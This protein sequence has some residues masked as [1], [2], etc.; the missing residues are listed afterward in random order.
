M[1]QSIS[2]LSSRLSH[3]SGDVPPPLVGASATLVDPSSSTSSLT[4]SSAKLYVFGGR[5]VSNRRMV[6]DLYELD[7]ETLQWKKLGQGP[8]SSDTNLK[9]LALA[10]PSASSTSSSSLSSAK[11]P[12]P[13]Y[14]HSADLWEGRIVIFG[15]MGYAPSSAASH[16]RDGKTEELC[17]LD[18]IIAYD[19][20][21]GTWDYDFAP[22]QGVADEALQ[23]P[24]IVA[25]KPAPRYAHLSSISGDSLIIIGGQNMTNQYVEHINVFSLSRRRW[26]ASQR[27]QRQC[28]SY[29]SLAVGSRYI[30]T[31]GERAKCYPRGRDPLNGAHDGA[32]ERGNSFGP[33][34]SS[35]LQRDRATSVS[36]QRSVNS[37]RSHLS[38]SQSAQGDL[39]NNSSALRDTGA[40]EVSGTSWGPNP[41]LAPVQVEQNPLPTS[42][43]P[44]NSGAAPVYIY[45]NYNFTDVR[46]ELELIRVK[47]SVCEAP[48]DSSAP[49]TRARATSFGSQDSETDVALPL[50]PSESHRSSLSG[51]YVSVED[52]SS[53]MGGAALPPGLRFPTG[54]ILGN[55]LIISGTYLANATQTF[56]IWALHLPTLTWSRL[57]AGSCLASGSWNKAIL[58]PGKNRL[59]V[60]GNKE[61]DL[62]SDYNHRQTNWDHLVILE[63]ESWGIYQPPVSRFSEDAVQMGLQKLALT[64]SA[65]LSPIGP[66]PVD[67]DPKKWND[68][69]SAARSG[70]D[71]SGGPERDQHKPDLLTPGF[72]SSGVLPLSPRSSLGGRGDFEIIC[73]DGLRIGC[74]RA[75]LEERWPWFHERMDEFRKRAR[76][77]A[78]TLIP[79]SV[80]RLPPT[81]FSSSRILDGVLEVASSDE[82]A[83]PD[84]ANE[85]GKQYEPR[86]NKPNVSYVNDPRFQPR[87]FSMSEPAPVVL[88]F[89]QFIYTQRV[90]TAL[91]RHPAIVCALLILA[92]T[93]ELDNLTAWAR[94]AAHVALAD[95]LNPRSQASSTRSSTL[96][97]S[98]TASDRRSGSDLFRPSESLGLHPEERHRLAVNLYEASSLCGCEGLQ[99]RALR[100]VMAIA[101]WMQK[102]GVS[103]HSSGGGNGGGPSG[104]L[105]RSAGNGPDDGGAGLRSSGS[106]GHGQAASGLTV[107]TSAGSSGGGKDRSASSGP[108]SHALALGSTT[109]A[110]SVPANTAKPPPPSLALPPI[111]VLPAAPVSTEVPVDGHGAHADLGNRTRLTPTTEKVAG[112][113]SDG[114]HSRTSTPLGMLSVRRSSGPSGNPSNGDHDAHSSERLGLRQGSNR[115]RFSSLFGKGSNEEAASLNGFRARYDLDSPAVEEEDGGDTHSAEVQ[116]VAEPEFLSILGRRGSTELTAGAVHGLKLLQRSPTS[117]SGKSGHFNLQSPPSGGGSHGAPSPTASSFA[118]SSS[119][120]KVPATME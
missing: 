21:T 102:H 94:H 41:I 48:A 73:S 26:V 89:L 20:R 22:N 114:A 75:I 115:K 99:I 110:S 112:T 15:G 63:L 42:H 80:D 18:E 36:T 47:S 93:Y 16:S 28:G 38:A 53:E 54:S 97:L 103:S 77:S 8:P 68:A 79:N 56:S 29:R 58:W 24:S 85:A 84:G 2:N 83:G 109:R 33:M 10:S 118:N 30:V 32:M 25:S 19:L 92:R 105:P 113:I 43:V 86:S 65:A 82:E 70:P 67:A 5:L 107:T 104:P 71:H 81:S 74:D 52:K 27:F 51:H 72:T 13:R 6:N 1:F 96:F 64:A 60:V 12:Q 23:S 111:G 61:R 50:S 40:P 49:G 95:D 46:R 45:S 3:C 31:E 59:L 57:D 76:R 44:S 106:L 120:C 62:V 35:A 11:G 4:I 14:F 7:L 98:S 9:S 66:K 116:K 78:R 88:A 108:P 117:G 87:Q 69:A 39:Y 34:E 119:P 91:Q 100:V 55:H 17:V 37:S 101:R 90:C